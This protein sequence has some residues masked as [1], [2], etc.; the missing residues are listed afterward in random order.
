[1]T[2][3]LALRPRETLPGSFLTLQRIAK[4][5]FS[6][7]CSFERWHQM[8]EVIGLR[9]LEAPLTEVVAFITFSR[10]RN[11]VFVIPLSVP[12]PV[13]KE[14]ELPFVGGIFPEVTHVVIIPV[15][16]LIRI[17]L[18]ALHPVQDVDLRQQLRTAKVA[19]V[20]EAVIR[21]DIE[22][23]RKRRAPQTLTTEVLEV[24]G[25]VQILQV[26]ELFACD[27]ERPALGLTRIVHHLDLVMSRSEQSELLV[28][29]QT[30]QSNF[31]TRR[32]V[33]EAIVRI[34]L[35]LEHREVRVV[36]QF[37]PHR[38]RIRILT[39]PLDLLV[40]VCD[41]DR[42]HELHV[43]D[44]P[45]RMARPL[46]AGLPIRALPRVTV[47]AIV[48]MLL[49][50]VLRVVRQLGRQMMELAPSLDQ[51]T[52][53]RE[54]LGLMPVFPRTFHLFPIELRPLVADA[55]L[56][57][58]TAMHAAITV[59]RTLGRLGP[60]ILIRVRIEVIEVGVARI[61]VPSII[62][63]VVEAVVARRNR[64][65][66]GGEGTNATGLVVP[67]IDAGNTQKPVRQLRCHETLLF[68]K[69]FVE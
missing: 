30:P 1:M 64:N 4:L 47:R 42:A 33:R 48:A 22:P 53:L 51:E 40:E 16:I 43:L 21:D 6:E 10:D 11:L 60:H 50:I 54:R 28:V 24:V 45:M 59:R 49:E 19:V 69:N 63:P 34:A 46:L 25:L 36:A 57:I 31:L 9:H 12:V 52:E 56:C 58:V 27:V 65:D 14:H 55:I 2:F 15:F 29:F 67:T 26:A 5:P 37:A 3:P 23:C 17:I 35:L 20:V 61:I 68:K 44:G 7:P 39:P 13:L 32:V 38:L 8:N 66:G 18:E 41:L 62:A